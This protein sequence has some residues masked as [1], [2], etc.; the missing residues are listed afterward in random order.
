MELKPR[1]P[2]VFQAARKAFNQTKMELK[3]VL[4]EGCA[5]GINAF[6]QTKMELKPRRHINT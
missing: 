6:N 2:A 1:K 5:T 4:G 3:R